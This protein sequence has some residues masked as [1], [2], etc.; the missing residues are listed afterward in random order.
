MKTT[1][2]KKASPTKSK[3]NPTSKSK[4]KAK[5]KKQPPLN[6][7]EPPFDASRMA[8]EKYKVANNCYAYAFG[9]IRSWRPHKS[10]PGARTGQNGYHPYTHCKGIAERIISDN[11]GR[12]YKASA[13]EKCLPGFYKAM[14]VVAPPNGFKAGGDF[15]FYR[16]HGYVKYKIKNED[17]LESV[18]KFFGVPRL[19]IVRACNKAGGFM[20]GRTI[21]FPCNLFSHKRGWATGALLKDSKGKRIDNP[22]TAGRNYASLNYSKYCNSFCVKN[23]NI[24]VG[25][26]CPGRCP[27]LPNKPL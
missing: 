16:Q 26:V 14:M 5:V 7:T 8:I 15:H 10:V 1:R 9:D 13:N 17:T 2:A 21:G 18:V 11:K 25:P 23:R 22:I 24:R 6:G 12:V 4:P 27:R 19:R 20:P 3:S